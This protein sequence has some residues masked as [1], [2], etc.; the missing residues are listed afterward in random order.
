MLRVGAYSRGSVVDY[1]DASVK[2][3]V[4]PHILA[5][6]LRKKGQLKL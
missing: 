2:R 5:L 6:F 1:A 4:R 3:H